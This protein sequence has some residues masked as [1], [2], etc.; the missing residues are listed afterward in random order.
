MTTQH[1]TEPSANNAL[2]DLLRPMLPTCLVRTEQT[3]TIVG[4]PGRHP[5]ILITAAGRSPVVVE[6]EYEPGAPTPK[7]MRSHGWATG[8]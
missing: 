2:G 5:D 7:K 6:A 3:Q 1:Q 8:L 4:N